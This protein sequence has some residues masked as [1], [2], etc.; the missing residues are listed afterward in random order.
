MKDL[1]SAIFYFED[2]ADAKGDSER[3]ALI[4]ATTR[5]LKSILVSIEEGIKGSGFSYPCISILM[6]M[7]AETDEK[8]DMLRTQAETLLECEELHRFKAC[9]NPCH[10]LHDALNMHLIHLVRSPRGVCARW[11]LWPE[12]P[13]FVRA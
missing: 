5:K 4:Q 7:F 13:L 11:F 3:D 10:L 9:L 1:R 2:V 8:I 6:M 12:A